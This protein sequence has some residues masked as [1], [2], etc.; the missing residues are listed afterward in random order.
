MLVSWPPCQSLSIQLCGQ[1]SEKGPQG[2]FEL[3]QRTNN[4]RVC[5]F[6]AGAILVEGQRVCLLCCLS[7]KQLT[8]RDEWKVCRQSKREPRSSMAGVMIRDREVEGELCL[9]PSTYRCGLIEGCF[10]AVRGWQVGIIISYLF[11]Q[12]TLWLTFNDC[13]MCSGSKHQGK[14]ELHYCVE[15]FAHLFCS[16]L[17]VYMKMLDLT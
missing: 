16:P 6:C 8:H 15:T 7:C 3:I 11:M 5:V 14:F 12:E 9:E 4:K 2:V 13:S 10:N 1:S 17:L